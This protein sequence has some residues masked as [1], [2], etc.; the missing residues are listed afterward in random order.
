MINDIT[1][2]PFVTS[3]TPV[4]ADFAIG[5][6]PIVTML[7]QGQVLRV[8]ATVSNDRQHVMM[9]LNPTFSTLIKTET[10]K[11]FG[12]DETTEETETTR[13]DDTASTSTDPRS[14]A[15]KTT[16]ARSGVTIQQPIMAT[17]SVMTTVS[18]PDGGTAL[19]G[20]IKRLSEGRVEAGVPMLNKIPDLQR[21]FTNQAMGRDTPSVMIMVTPRIIIQEEEEH[22]LMGTMGRSMP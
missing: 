14:S 17:F 4:V 16:V 6:Q 12:D 13:G 8:L 20:G 3:V 2:V 7:N 22:H 18:C 5:Y 9:T 11:Y 15:K 21:L 10:F 19:L 1:Q